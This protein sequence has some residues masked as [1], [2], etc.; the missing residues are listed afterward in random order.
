MPPA[1]QNPL[2]I[3]ATIIGYVIALPLAALFIRGIFFVGRTSK[4]FDDLVVS[5][6]SIEARLNLQD[7]ESTA[8]AWSFAVVEED[9][10]EL[11]QKAGLPVREYP[12][13]RLIAVGRRSA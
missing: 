12:D 6:S 8:N 11:Q 9:I 13:R 2:V 10:Q 3:A 5:V 1:S 4:R 7:R